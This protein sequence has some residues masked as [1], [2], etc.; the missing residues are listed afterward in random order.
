MDEPRQEMNLPGQAAL[1][2]ALLN[3]KVYGNDVTQVDKLETHISYV[4]LAG[5][6]AYK[7]K[8][9]VDL[10]FLNFLTLSARRFYCLEELRLNRQFA[11]FLYLDVIAVTGSPDHPVLGGDGPP[12]EYAVK[13]RRFSQAD[14]LN[15]V[16]AR[17]ALSPDLIDRLAERIAAIHASAAVATSR[18]TYGTPDAVRQPVLDNFLRIRASDSD[19]GKIAD[20]DFLEQWTRAQCRALDVV[21]D[22]RKN[23]GFV[24]ECHG[25]LH[26]GNVALVDGAVTIFD[27]L[28]FNPGFRWID[29]M[30]EVAFLVMDL[31]DRNRPDLARRLLNRYLEITGGY[32]G[33]R[34]LRFYTVYRALVRAK[35]HLLR[36][37][38]MGI[39]AGDTG[40]K[41][42]L[43]DQYRDYVSLAKDQTISSPPALLITHGLSGSG[44]TARTQS[45]LEAAGAVRIRSD[46]ERKRLHGLTALA[47][48]GSALTSG[49]YTEDA[50]ALT[51]Q[52]LS[53]LAKTA[54]E[55]GYTVIVD[56]TFLKRR[57]RDMFRRLAETLR[58]P[59]VILDFVANENVMRARILEREKRRRD[60]SE[61][62]IAVLE[63]QLTTQE[64]LEPEEEPFVE[65]FDTTENITAW[66]SLLR[67]IGTTQLSR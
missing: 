60:A 27:C 58:V 66:S 1:A 34:V 64:R 15:R 9:A 61:A 14:L 36:A 52:R 22:A 24:R 2:A 11:P 50:T 23:S 5:A 41:T 46:V 49:A 43:L 29:V 47:R 56:A 63:H 35:V 37:G 20:L 6:Y 67:R 48:T 10:G 7:I 3:P 13:M 21:F 40:D 16:L 25:D 39:N 8:K 42:C 31:Q 38:Q 62:G 53:D 18:D 57:Q 26:L 12:I 55:A 51:Y 28:E 54:I 45:L 33:L 4:F 65:R 17:G 44:K 19:S 59:F 30:S 32:D